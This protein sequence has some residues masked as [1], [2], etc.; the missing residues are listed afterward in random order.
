MKDLK[1]GDKIGLTW[2]KGNGDGKIVGI[3]QDYIMVIHPCFGKPSVVHRNDITPPENEKPVEIT[4]DMVIKWVIEEIERGVCFFRK[5]IHRTYEKGCRSHR[6]I[7]IVIGVIRENHRVLKIN[8]G[9]AIGEGIT[10]EQWEVKI[11]EYNYRCAYCGRRCALTMDHVISL[12]KG[13]DHL[14]K[15]VVPACTECNSRKGVKL[16]QPKIFKKIV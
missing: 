4:K 6:Q 7:K 16:W 1:I 13:G 9:M 5:L 12:S 15:N 8:N 11:R 14:I 2:I 3:Y 10:T